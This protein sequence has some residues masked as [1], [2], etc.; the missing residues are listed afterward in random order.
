LASTQEA[1]PM[2][3]VNRYKRI[4]QAI[5]SVAMRPNVGRLMRWSKILKNWP[6]RVLERMGFI[7]GD[8]R[9][10]L[11]NGLKLTM[12]GDSEDGDALVLW[13]IY[14]NAPYTR[15]HFSIEPGETVVDI[16]AHVGIFATWVATVEPTTQI[17]AFE[18]NPE[19]YEYLK[20]NVR[21][22]QLSN[23][24]LSGLA[25]SGRSGMIKL[26]MYEEGYASHTIYRSRAKAKSIPQSIEVETITL[27]EVFRRHEIRQIGLLKMDCEGAEYEILFATPKFILAKI[28][29]IAMEYHPVPGYSIEDLIRF[30]SLLNFKVKKFSKNETILYAWQ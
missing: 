3:A 24:T 25:V 8:L 30:L 11:K 14:V 6:L 23:I 16:G 29:K 19:T 17:Y 12:K 9:Y 1:N 13:D 5:L 27:E 4:I 10:R 7:S 2:L 18:A 22:N 26:Y 21:Q 28:Q 15:E 20:K